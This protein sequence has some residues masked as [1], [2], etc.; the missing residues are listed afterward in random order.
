MAEMDAETLE[1]LKGSIAKWEKIT[2][3]T[4]QDMGA[5][6]C[7]LCQMFHKSAGLSLSCAG[8]PVAEA[9]GAFGCDGSPYAAYERHA[10]ECDYDGPGECP[11]CASLAA[12][13][14]DFLKSLLPAARKESPAHD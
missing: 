3:G 2:A 7:S 12:A 9:T 6:N 13:E 14:L 5:S 1:A 10:M 11:K 4:G 8:C